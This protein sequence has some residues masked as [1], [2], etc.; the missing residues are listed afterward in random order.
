MT[1]GIYKTDNDRK[2]KK[3]PFYGKKHTEETIKKIKEKR[4]LQIFS[5]ETKA[6][7]GESNSGKKS[8]N[9][10][11]GL[12]KLQKKEKLAGRKRP[13]LCEICKVVTKDYERGLNFDHDHKTGRFRGWICSR[14]NTA[15][16]MVDDNI[17]ILKLLI[18]YL[19]NNKQ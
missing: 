5:D 11:G 2:G 4:K 15:L 8:G 9:W 18:K 3:N 16:A 7:I 13:E 1:S 12:T 10:K 19:E 14:C 17:K 6:K